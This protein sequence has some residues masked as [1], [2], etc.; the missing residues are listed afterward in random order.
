MSEEKLIE[1]HIN[2][3]LNGGS[4]RIALDFIA[5]FRTNAITPDQHESGDGWSSHFRKG[6]SKPLSLPVDVS[7]P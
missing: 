1:A 6:I 3:V 7:Q 4:K 5:F 2:E